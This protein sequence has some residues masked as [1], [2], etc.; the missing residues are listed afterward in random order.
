MDPGRAVTCALFLASS[1]VAP[2][3]SLPR[4]LASVLSAQLLLARC[5]GEAC[6]GTPQQQVFRSVQEQQDWC[7]VD[8]RMSAGLVELPVAGQC[9]LAGGPSSL[10]W[11]RGCNACE[12]V[13]VLCRAE[14]PPFDVCV[15]MRMSCTRARGCC[16]RLQASRGFVAAP[17]MSGYF[18]EARVH[19]SS[20]KVRG[21]GVGG[22]GVDGPVVSPGSGLCEVCEG[23]RG[24]PARLD[25]FCCRLI[26][27]PSLPGRRLRMASNGLACM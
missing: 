1:L 22:R 23:G 16:V 17:S 13:G 27:R 4:M 6:A 20:V 5:W 24:R 2:A 12:V 15:C 10:L 3:G 25:I 11:S 18:R 8:G 9:S 14:L 19:P 26:K 21:V 7:C